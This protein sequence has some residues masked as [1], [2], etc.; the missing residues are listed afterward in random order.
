[1]L[2]GNHLIRVEKE[3][4]SEIIHG[5]L[6]L[7]SV[8]ETMDDIYQEGVVIESESLNKG[9]KL[10]LLH[11]Y[12]QN[13]SIKKNE[14]IIDDSKI[15]A[16]N[17]KVTDEWI[18]VERIKKEAQYT[19]SGILT[20]VNLDE[21]HEDGDGDTFNVIKNDFEH[22]AFKVISEENKGYTAIIKKNYDYDVRL[23]EGERVFVRK[24][25]IVFYFDKQGG[26][27]ESGDICVFKK[28]EGEE[29]ADLNGILVKQKKQPKKIA[30]NILGANRGHKYLLD[31]A[32]KVMVNDKSYYYCYK[33]RLLAD[34]GLE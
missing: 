29:W 3:Y 9:D 15:I 1:M 8:S 12:T 14:F 13:P 24:A 17:N 34:Y 6:N 22:H 23:E 33:D 32:N 11:L 20:S 10:I 21:V 5:D 31:T 27:V 4:R 2:N 19:E 25:G 30:V 7:V 28:D 18:E 26:M 16:I